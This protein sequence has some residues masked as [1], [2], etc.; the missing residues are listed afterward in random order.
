MGGRQWADA[1]GRNVFSYTYDSFAYVWHM[2]TPIRVM[3]H[4]RMSHVTY[5]NESCHIRERVMSYMRTSHVTYE[6]ESC[7]ICERV[8]SHTRMMRPVI[9]HMCLTWLC[10]LVSAYITHMQMSHIMWLY[11]HVR[12]V[13]DMTGRIILVCDMTRS[14]M[15]H[16]SFSYVTRLVRICDMT[17]SHMWLDSFAYMTW[18][19]LICDST[20]SHM[21]HD[22]FS[23][24]TWLVRICD[25]WHDSFAH[26]TPV[27]ING[28]TLISQRWNMTNCI[29][30]RTRSR[31]WH[32]SFSHGTWLIPMYDVYMWRDSF[33]H[34][35]S[36]R[37]RT[38][39]CDTFWHQW[40]QPH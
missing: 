36:W 26:G 10:T 40:A 3:S 17:H 34:V 13:C 23:Y 19:I 6:N 16:D 1:N 18:L 27:D 11:N 20:R 25:M 5:A 7:H 29:L 9:S 24:V 2:L 8:M 28:H 12:L 35:S 21:W 33:S 14:H 4:M 30:D 37:I 39:D 15:W 38:C 22:S 32:D 31:V